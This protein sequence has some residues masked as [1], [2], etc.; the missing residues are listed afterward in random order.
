MNYLAHFVFNHQVCGLPADPYFALGVVLP[1][2]WARYS[3]R[4]RLRWRAVRAALPADA[5]DA[6]LQAGLLNH[7]EVDRRFHTL[8]LFAQWQAATRAAHNGNGAHPAVLDFVAHMA[9]ELALDHHLLRAK[10][11]LADRLYDLLAMC[12][13]ELAAE[14][15]GRLGAVDAGGLGPIIRSFVGRRY[16]HGYVRRDGLVEAI[17][18]V[19]TAAEI[20]VPQ[21]DALH[22]YL[23]CALELVDPA[24]LWAELG[25]IGPLARPT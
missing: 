7:V 23:G 5:I 2:L 1:D 16:M 24:R 17:G 4:K 13:P 10:V 20:P 8:P 9:V 19:L 11:G 21:A 22:A 18:L 6:A 15:A 3:R 25:P 14:R 12:D